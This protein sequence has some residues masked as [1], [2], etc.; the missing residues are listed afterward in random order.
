MGTLF[1]RQGELCRRRGD[2]AAAMEPLLQARDRFEALGN[3]LEIA[4]T[5]TT[6]GLADADLGHTAGAAAAY[7][8][9]LAWLRTAKGSDRLEV[10][11]RLSFAQL[12][13]DEGRFLEA[14]AEIRRAERLAVTNNLIRRLVQLYTLLGNLRARQGD[15]TGFVFFEQAL[16]LA[17]MIDR[18]PMIEA[19]VYHEY[20]M[21]KLLMHQPEDG[22]AYLRRA[23]E[24]FESIG[25][26]AEVERVVADLRRASA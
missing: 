12:H 17:R 26:D 2:A 20:G 21:F 11:I 6:R 19:R 10:F 23:R 15:D 9:A 16:Q 13:V 8:E 14:E 18:R 24:I 3:A 7:R 22:R 5:L 1:H 25:L 4:R